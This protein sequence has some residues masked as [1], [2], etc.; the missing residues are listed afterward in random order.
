MAMGRGGEG[1]NLPV[2]IPDIL[3][4]SPSPPRPRQNYLKEFL[5]PPRIITGDPRGSPIPK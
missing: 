3:R 1:T 4:M 2:F 5:S